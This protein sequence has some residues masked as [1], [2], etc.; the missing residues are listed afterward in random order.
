MEK[1]SKIAVLGS[2]GLVGSAIIRNLKQNGYTNILEVN[3]SVCNL[4]D[5]IAVDIFLKKNKPEYVFLAA[6]KVGG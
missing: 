3:R 6:G 4:L 5:T 1:K 2:S